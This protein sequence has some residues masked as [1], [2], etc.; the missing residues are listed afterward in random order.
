MNIDGE[1]PM[2]RLKSEAKDSLYVEQ[3]GKCLHHAKNLNGLENM[4]KVKANPRDQVMSMTWK[5]ASQPLYF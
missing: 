4:T 1:V 2:M 3:S 5:S